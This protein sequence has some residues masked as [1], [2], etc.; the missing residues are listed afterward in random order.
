[1]ISNILKDCRSIW[2]LT[3]DGKDSDDADLE[4]NTEVQVPSKR[5]LYEQ[6]SRVQIH[7]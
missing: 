6:S 5:L 7:L 1:M 4:E 2:I 3:R